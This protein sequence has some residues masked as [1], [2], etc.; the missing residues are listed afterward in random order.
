MTTHTYRSSVSWSDSTTDY[1][2]YDRRHEISIGAA[3]LGSVPTLRSAATEALRS[4]VGGRWAW[5]SALSGELDDLVYRGS[6]LWC[7]EGEI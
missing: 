6:G 3:P 5:C 4:V 7:V 2:S 1:G